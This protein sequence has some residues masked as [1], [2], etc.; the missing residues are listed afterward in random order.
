MIA[1]GATMPT[2]PPAAWKNLN[3]INISI[4]GANAEPIEEII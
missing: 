4:V 1:R 3:A 2:Q